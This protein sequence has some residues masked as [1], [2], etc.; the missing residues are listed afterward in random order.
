M[1]GKKNLE[2]GEATIVEDHI[3]H[4]SGGAGMGNLHEWV[5]DVRA[6]GRE[7]F[8]TVI[9]TPNLATDFRHPSQ[10]DIVSVFIDPKDNEVT[11]DKSD[12]RLSLKA[13]R[14]ARNVQFQSSATDPVAAT[15]VVDAG[16]AAPLLHA[17]FSADPQAKARAIAE[18]KNAAPS[19][20]PD[21]A[22][23][24]AELDRLKA[25]GALSPDEYDAQRQRILDSI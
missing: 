12:P 2:A 7:A 8:R 18:L 22:T 10:G 20:G 6:P 5:A 19:A 3:K 17:L 25:S 15:Q 23:R 1:F 24:L 13:E 9:A 11:F 4:H 21:I 14:S 16:D